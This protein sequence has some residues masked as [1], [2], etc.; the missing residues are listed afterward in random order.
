MALTRFT[1]E[2]DGMT[3]EGEGVVTVHGAPDADPGP[4]IAEFLGNVDPQA[5]EEQALSRLGWG[6]NGPGAQTAE[7]LKILCELAA[8]QVAT[9]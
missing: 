9:T 6:G 7:V 3:I 8:G 1:I 5:L 2:L 4:V